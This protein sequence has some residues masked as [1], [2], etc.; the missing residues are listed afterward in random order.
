[1]NTKLILWIECVA[2]FLAGPVLFWLDWVTTSLVLL[3]VFIAC[4]PATVWL[5]RRYGFTRRVFWAGNRDD[6]RNQLRIVLWRFV[7]FSIILV[8]IV[9]TW[10]PEHVFD[11]P[12]QATG[13][14]LLFIFVYPVFSV[15]PQ[16]LLYRCFFFARYSRLFGDEYTMKLMS[17]IMFS[18]MHV[19]FHNVLAVFFTL[20]G[21][22]LFADTYSK[23][24]SLRLV[25]LEH[26]L[27]G[28]LLF[29]IGY[30]K[31]FLLEPYLQW[32]I[33]L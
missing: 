2:I 5:G 6:E 28:N 33:G 13:F 22:L 11:L 31:A 19:V 20:V 23:T 25:C 8:V 9:V 18:V 29:T 15:Y 30:G 32:I 24:R 21:G 7:F 26:A 17:A 12:Q 14:W 1:M 16:E 10:Y 27:Y 4:I 3:P